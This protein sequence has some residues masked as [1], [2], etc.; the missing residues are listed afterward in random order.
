MRP[1]FGLTRC[2]A[3]RA[4]SL[5]LNVYMEKMMITHMP[6]A[7]L[8]GLAIGAWLATSAL[9]S[10]CTPPAPPSPEVQA[11]EHQF[12]TGCRPVDAQGY[13]NQY[14]YCSKG[15]GGGRM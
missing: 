3:C 2:R 8:P 10:G 12:Q 13:E 5:S 4:K 6:R 11:L 14:P 7:V 1:Y 15:D 9:L